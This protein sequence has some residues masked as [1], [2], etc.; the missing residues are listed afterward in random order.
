MGQDEG[1][2]YDGT[3]SSR[4]CR[5]FLVTSYADEA[6]MRLAVE[7]GWEEDLLKYKHLMAP[8][9]QELITL[10]SNKIVCY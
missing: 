3:G 6:F 5:D 1:L 7:L 2:H 10:T 9:S 4:P 8:S